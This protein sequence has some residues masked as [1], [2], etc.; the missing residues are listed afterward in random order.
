[1]DD[2]QWVLDRMREEIE[3]EEAPST[4]RSLMLVLGIIK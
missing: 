3:G 2:D 1:M 4:S